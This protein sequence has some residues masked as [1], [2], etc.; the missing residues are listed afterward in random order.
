MKKDSA[1]KILG[2]SALGLIFLWLLNTVFFSSG[3]G[4]SVRYN[5]PSYYYSTGY[6]N[7]FGMN[8]FLISILKIVLVIFIFA[9]FAA[10]VMI[11]KNNLL[12]PEDIHAIK[13]QF[14][15]DFNKEIA[16]SD[17]KNS[18]SGIEEII[19]EDLNQEIKEKSICPE[20]GHELDPEWKICLNCGKEL[21]K[22]RK[23]KNTNN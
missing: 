3:Y 7:Y 15:N 10:V 20:C 18:I 11:V 16:E 19:A 22:S 6:N 12:K 2:L 5:M 21:K 17:T 9:F 14:T 23:K 4:M 13:E 8:G 1:L